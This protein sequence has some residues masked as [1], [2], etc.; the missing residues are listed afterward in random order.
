MLIGNLPLHGYTNCSLTWTSSVRTVFD[1][2]MDQLKLPEV[3]GSIL[4]KNLF[5]FCRIYVDCSI[6]IMISST[7]LRSTDVACI[8]GDG[9]LLYIMNWIGL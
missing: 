8:T 7:M 5:D 2:M 4:V 6:I 3:L 9:P 1:V